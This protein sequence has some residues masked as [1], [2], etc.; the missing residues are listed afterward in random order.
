[1]MI[2][3]IVHVPYGYTY[4]RTRTSTFHHVS[5]ITYVTCMIC[6]RSEVG[7]EYLVILR[8]TYSV[9][10]LPEYV[11]TVVV[12]RIVVRVVLLF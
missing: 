6:L 5:V 12:S 7:T 11:Y 8:I 3:R 9:S 4:V 10:V 2:V 1:M